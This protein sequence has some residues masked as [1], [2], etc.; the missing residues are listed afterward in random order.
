MNGLL[1]D[2]DYCRYGMKYRKRTRTW[3]KWKSWKPQP[4]C[5]KDCESIVSGRYIL[6]K[7]TER[8]EQKKKKVINTLY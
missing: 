5:K 4:L 1:F 6:L 2:V 3:I 7:N 8:L